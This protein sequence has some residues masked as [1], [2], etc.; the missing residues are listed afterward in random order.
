M[1]LDDMEMFVRFQTYAKKIVKQVDRTPHEHLW[2]LLLKK[3][4][5][6]DF[7][8]IQPFSEINVPF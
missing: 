6:D 5:L 4:L 1:Y 8:N 2:R 3:P 7:G